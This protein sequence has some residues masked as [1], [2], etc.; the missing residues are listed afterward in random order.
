MNSINFILTKMKVLLIIK[1]FFLMI[2]IDYIIIFALIANSKYLLGIIKITLLMK[3][4]VI[5]IMNLSVIKDQ[6][7]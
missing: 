7:V 5:I 1:A 4:N 2:M 6:V 3:V